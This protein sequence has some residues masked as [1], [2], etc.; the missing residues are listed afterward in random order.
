MNALV[1][2]FKQILENAFKVATAHH[3]SEVY[4][5]NF[6]YAICLENV[7]LPKDSISKTINEI[8]SLSQKVEERKQQE[9]IK[10]PLKEKIKTLF[11]K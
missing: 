10:K 3:Q 1:A 2:P 11:K 5:Y 4:L 7:K 6:Y 9:K 8:D